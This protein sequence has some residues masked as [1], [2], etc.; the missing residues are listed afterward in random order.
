MPQQ[1]EYNSNGYSAD[2]SVKV[3]QKIK[4]AKKQTKPKYEDPQLGPEPNY[5]SY[6]DRMQAIYAKVS[7]QAEQQFF[8]AKRE[9][10]LMQIYT[11]ASLVCAA[12]LQAR[13]EVNYNKW[14]IVEKHYARKIG[15]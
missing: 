13:D 5:G 7:Y 10:D 15:L 1:P 9:G 6:S 11:Q 3:Q 8:I 14:K 12:Y 2:T 4:P